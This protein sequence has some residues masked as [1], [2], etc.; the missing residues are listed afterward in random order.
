MRYTFKG[1]RGWDESLPLGYEET[2]VQI[3][4]WNNAVRDVPPG[5][6]LFILPGQLRIMSSLCHLTFST[7]LL[8]CNGWEN[9]NPDCRQKE[10]SAVRLPM[11]KLVPVRKTVYLGM[12]G[13]QSACT[14]CVLRQDVM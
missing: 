10:V 9:L 2:H 6:Q 5:E 3:H 1:L 4:S 13:P 11:M 8:V 7:Y 12:S 14:G